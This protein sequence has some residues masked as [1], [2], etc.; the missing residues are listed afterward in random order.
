M[1]HPDIFNLIMTFN[2]LYFNFVIIDILKDIHIKRGGFMK[3]KA[4]HLAL[5]L[6]IAACAVFSMSAMAHPKGG[7][8]YY[9]PVT[10]ADVYV[11]SGLSHYGSYYL[12]TE[13]KCVRV[14]AHKFH[15]HHYKAQTVCYKGGYYNS[16]MICG[17]V[18]GYWKHKSHVPGHVVCWQYR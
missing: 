17:W 8:E 11:G 18:H 7:F 5:A 4:H 13:N 12:T 10:G 6:G 16:T 14:P 1:L 9:D 2:I 15:G 3:G